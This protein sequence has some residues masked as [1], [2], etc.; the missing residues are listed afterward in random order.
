VALVEVGLNVVGALD[1]ADE[2]V[3]GRSLGQNTTAEVSINMVRKR[4][5]A[6]PYP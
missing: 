4:H 2:E 5:M 1:I 3:F 6:N